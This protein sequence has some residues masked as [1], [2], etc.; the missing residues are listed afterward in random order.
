RKPQND[1]KLCSD[2]HTSLKPS[3]NY[4][5]DENPIVHN[6]CKSDDARQLVRLQRAT[7]TVLHATRHLPLYVTL[8]VLNQ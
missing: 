3:H 6:N 7:L 4:A 1:D 2:V 8:R 5:S